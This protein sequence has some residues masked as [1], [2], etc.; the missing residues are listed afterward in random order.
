MPTSSAMP[1]AA[2]AI[3]SSER[4]R[5]AHEAGPQEEVLGRVAGD[6][7]LGEEREVGAGLPRLLEPVEDE[8]AVAVEVA[9]GR[10]DLRECEAHRV[11]DYQSKTCEARWLSP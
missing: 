8:G 7:E 4:S 2:C 5:R 9:D 6:G 10:V 11:S 3:C 1:R